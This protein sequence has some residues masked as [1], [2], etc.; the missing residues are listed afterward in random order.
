MLPMAEQGQPDQ[1]D[2]RYRRMLKTGQ[3]QR[4]QHQTPCQQGRHRGCAPSQQPRQWQHQG[5]TGAEQGR[6]FGVETGQ[7]KAVEGIDQDQR[8]HP[9]MDQTQRRP[10]AQAAI[11]HTQRQQQQ[12]GLGPSHQP[13]RHAARLTQTQRIAGPIQTQGHTADQHFGAVQA[14]RVARHSRLV[15]A[16]RCLWSGGA[17]RGVHQRLQTQTAGVA[18]HV[19]LIGES[20]QGLVG[21][22]KSQ[23][24]A[25]QQQRQPPEQALNRRR[26]SFEIDGRHQSG[27]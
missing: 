2:Q 15:A 3:G 1:Q 10:A 13:Q 5:Q 9:G 17:G 27:R 12:Q 18:Q 25:Q 26:S 21:Q 20:G 6:E 24:G 7:V 14:T 8:R 23:A 16:D 22:H 4:C 19:E 11:D